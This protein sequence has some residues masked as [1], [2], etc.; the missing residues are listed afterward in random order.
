MGEKTGGHMG[1]DKIGVAAF[2]KAKNNASA[3]ATLNADD[4]TEGSV[5]KSIK[6]AVDPIKGTGWTDENL[7]DIQ[8]DTVIP[9]SVSIDKVVNLVDYNDPDTIY[10]GYIRATGTL[11]VNILYNSTGFIPVRYGK[12]YTSSLQ[13]VLVTWWDKDKNL[14]GDTGSVVF[15]NA[16]YVEVT[17]ANAVY[18]RFIGIAAEWDK[19]QV[20]E[21]DAYRKNRG[22]YPTLKNLDITK[23]LTRIRNNLFNTENAVY[24][25]YLHYQTGV[26]TVYKNGGYVM[27]DVIPDSF[28]FGKLPRLG[29]NGVALSVMYFIVGFD[30]NGNYVNYFFH[31]VYGYFSTITDKFIIKIPPTVV[32]IGISFTTTANL[33]DA[34]IIQNFHDLLDADK[35]N[36]YWLGDS[37]IKR[38]EDY[39]VYDIFEQIPDDGL[40]AGYITSAGTIT[41]SD[42]I[43]CSIPIPVKEGEVYELSDYAEVPTSLS[44]VGIFLDSNMKK[45][46]TISV[47]QT[48]VTQFTIPIG[49]SYVSILW[50][51]TDYEKPSLKKV[52]SPSYATKIAAN[53]L[54]PPIAGATN[55]WNGKKWVSLGDSITYR[56][57]WQPFVVTEFGLVHTNCGIGSTYLAGT[58]ATAFWQDVRLNAVKAA[59]PDIVTILGGANDLV[60]NIPIGT[61]AEFDLA[62]ASKDTT[63]FKGAY[64]YIVENLLTWKPTLKLFLLTTTFAHN[65]GADLAPSSGLRYTDYAQATKEV[66]QFYGIPCIDLHGESGFNKMTNSTYLPDN[67]HPNTAGGKRIAEVVIGV[68]KRFN[69]IA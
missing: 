35:I 21:D 9:L 57:E 26:P 42:T 4:T 52:Y 53:A 1:L 58:S 36:S 56:N 38:S 33:E 45:Y 31:S 40:F 5:A 39:H 25:Y 62:L 14:I 47:P 41:S 22:S 12:K 46:S 34:F 29:Y 17:Y 13:S 32:K 61:D 63:T 37:L 20:H 55:G 48:E 69:P 16:G 51:V 24:G 15:A 10:G 66:A 3:I 27:L 59:T 19:F 60:A 7:V 43:A 64:S 6:D 68:M 44:M 11:A 49:V 8:A 67:V 65:D 28:Y 30:A 18:A 23:P 54:Y 2:K 50:I